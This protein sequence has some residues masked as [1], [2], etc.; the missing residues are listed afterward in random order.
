V[1]KKKTFYG[2]ENRISK[3]VEVMSGSWGKH[4]VDLD[5]KFW[6]TGSSAV[7]ATR[8]NIHIFDFFSPL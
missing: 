7:V 8:Y 3:N 2:I 1:T 4:F 5:S 6:V